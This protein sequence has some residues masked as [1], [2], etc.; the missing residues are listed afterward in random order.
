MSVY[1]HIKEQVAIDRLSIEINDADF[2]TEYLYSTFTSPNLSIFFDGELTSQ[3]QTTLSGLVAAHSGQEIYLNPGMVAVSD[4]SGSITFVSSAD[5]I[6]NTTF[7]FNNLQDAPSNYSS[8]P[9]YN[10][11]VNAAGTALELYDHS[12][13]YPFGINYQ[14]I[15]SCPEESTTSEEWIHKATLT[16]SGIVPGEYRIGWTYEYRFETTNW[17][18]ETRVLINENEDWI[19]SSIANRATN[20]D[21]WFPGSGFHIMPVTVSGNYNITLEYKTQKHNFPAHIRR[22]RMDIWRVK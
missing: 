5:E 6:N 20:A 14:F 2:S 11:R 17:Q 1:N 10:I 16:A 4:G 19:L 8:Y 21:D 15:R 13:E 7:R 9:Y 3:E 22:V 12:S 18:M